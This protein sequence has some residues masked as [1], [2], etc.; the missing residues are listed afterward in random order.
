MA[1]DG[2]R[3]A[4]YLLSGYNS[5]GKLI[6]YLSIQMI[7]RIDNSTGTKIDDVNTTKLYTDASSTIWFNFGGVQPLST[8]K[9]GFDE[10]GC[11]NDVFEEYKAIFI[12]EVEKSVLSIR[13]HSKSIS[14]TS[15]RY[16]WDS[17]RAI[18]NIPIYI[19]RQEKVIGIKHEKTT[20]RLDEKDMTELRQVVNMLNDLYSVFDGIISE[21][22]V[23]KVETIGDGYLC[24]SGLPRRNGNEHAKNIADMALAFIKSLNRFSIPHLPGQTI[25]LRIGIHTDTVVAG[26]VGLSMPRYC[27]FGDSVNTAARMESSG[28]PD[29]IQLS[30]AA[31]HFLTNIVGGYATQL[32]GEVIIKGKG[33]METYWLLGHESD[34]NVQRMLREMD[35]EFCEQAG[36][37]VA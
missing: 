34:P 18:N 27:L 30:H 31:N 35:K 24:V 12:E 36:P 3:D 15:T 4:N 16:T 10:L 7:T 21:R 22:D 32:R 25:N 6:S 14:T 20:I 23:Y 1:Q 17:T 33:V 13:S 28:K 11:P 2:F 19:Y 37:V 8:P 29:K 26:V 9:C 5:Q